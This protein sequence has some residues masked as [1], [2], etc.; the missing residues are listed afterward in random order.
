[1]K[2]K[3][4]I[5][6]KLEFAVVMLVLVWTVPNA[7]TVGVQRPASAAVATSVRVLPAPSQSVARKKLRAARLKL[8]KL[9][10]L[11]AASKDSPVVKRRLKNSPNLVVKNKM[12]FI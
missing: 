11:R 5:V 10:K 12:R 7:L 8:R 4:V 6:E 2:L 3:G 1:M 9:L